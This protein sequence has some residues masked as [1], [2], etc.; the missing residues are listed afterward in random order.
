MQES[1]II[2]CSRCGQEKE[3]YYSEFVVVKEDHCKCTKVSKPINGLK[4][5]DH[6]IKVLNDEKSISKNKRHSKRN[7]VRI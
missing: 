6:F 3:L 1:E 4:P 2:I 7:S 5:L